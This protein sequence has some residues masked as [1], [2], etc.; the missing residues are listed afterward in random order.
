MGVCVCTRVH[1]RVYIQNKIMNSLDITFLY[2]NILINKYHNL[3]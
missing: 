1:A 2:T 3:L